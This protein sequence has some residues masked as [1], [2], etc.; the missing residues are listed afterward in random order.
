MEPTR[1]S[2]TPKRRTG[3]AF[4]VW[5]AQQEFPEQEAHHRTTEE[6]SGTNT[7]HFKPVFLSPNRAHALPNAFRHKRLVHHVVEI[8]R[9]IQASPPI[10]LHNP[11]VRPIH[12][13]SHVSHV[14]Q[15]RTLRQSH[16]GLDLPVGRNQLVQTTARS[17]KDDVRESGSMRRNQDISQRHVTNLIHHRDPLK[18]H[19]LQLQLRRETHSSHPPPCC[20]ALAQRRS[21]P[22]RSRSREPPHDAATVRADTRC[23]VASR[24]RR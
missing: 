9:R 8:P 24:R 6:H 11:H 22:P 7:E 17:H 15:T 4:M 20:T 1:R 5:K 12:A 23:V 14:Q 19:G 21:S 10:R 3:P 18:H 13:L 16:V 2:T